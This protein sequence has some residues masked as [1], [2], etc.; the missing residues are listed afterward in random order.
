MKWTRFFKGAA[1]AG[2][3]VTTLFVKSTGIALASSGDSNSINEKYGP[4]VIVYGAQ[5]STSQKEEVRKL[6]EVTDP[7]QVREITA[8]GQDLVNYIKGDA[9][10]NMYS[11]AKITRDDSGK[12]II[13][14]IVTPENITEVTKDM[15]ANALLTAGVKDAVVDVAAPIKVSGH[16]ALVG[17]YKA[18]DT[19]KGANLNKDRTEVASE[20]LS[21]AT[22]LAKKD[23]MNSDKV[24]QLLTEIKQEIAAQHPATKEDIANIVDEKLKSLNISLNDKDRQMLIDLFDK[25]RNLNIN[26]DNVKS[27]LDNLAQDVKQKV[28]NAVDSGFFQKVADFFQKLIDAIKSIFS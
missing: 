27:Q 14:N 16:S 2:V 12:G 11:S 7:S 9:H 25:M 13:V 15:Y 20:E 6:L 5:L 17:I 28:E 18:Y 10:A 19:G 23:G 1:I 26:F 21:L 24:T 8:T 22:N 4:P 3:L